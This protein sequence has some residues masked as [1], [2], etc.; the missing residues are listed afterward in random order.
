[1]SGFTVCESNIHCD[2]KKKNMPEL[3]K[4]HISELIS[5]RPLILKAR[6]LN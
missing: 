5:G 1:M 2:L 4:T 3:K 6:T